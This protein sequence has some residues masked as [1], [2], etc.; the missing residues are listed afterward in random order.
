MP[1]GVTYGETCAWPGCTK[2]ISWKQAWCYRHWK[3][4]PAEGDRR[5]RTR[6]AR[7]GRRQQTTTLARL[8]ATGES[9]AGRNGG[10]GVCEWET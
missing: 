1:R 8:R 7:L 2:A 9:A 4:V 10:R 6:C 5:G 3:M